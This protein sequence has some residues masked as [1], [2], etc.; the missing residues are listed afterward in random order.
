M[1]SEPIPIWDGEYEKEPYLLFAPEGAVYCWPNAGK[2][3]AMDGSGREWKPEDN[4][5]VKRSTIDELA[6][7]EKTNDGT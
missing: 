2:M 1:P 7:R 5:R 4:V 6:E 3:V